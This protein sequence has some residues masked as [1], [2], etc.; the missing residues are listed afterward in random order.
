M[1]SPNILFDIFISQKQI[2]FTLPPLK[3]RA[4]LNNFSTLLKKIK[5][6][7]IVQKE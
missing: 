5:I 4:N 3:L 1:Y 2:Y 6:F 7:T